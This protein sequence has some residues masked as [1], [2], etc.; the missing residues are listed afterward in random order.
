MSFH[1]RKKKSKQPSATTEPSSTEAEESSAPF[2]SPREE[3]K[4]STTTILNNTISPSDSNG[5]CRSAVVSTCDNNNKD[6]CAENGQSKQTEVENS[7]ESR[8]IVQQPK[9]S[10]TTTTVNHSSTAK[11]RFIVLSRFFSPWKWRRKKKSEKNF[12]G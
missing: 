1:K 8:N 12:K 4:P 2:D 9:P 10:T 7:N 11:R 3:T 5:I 6:G